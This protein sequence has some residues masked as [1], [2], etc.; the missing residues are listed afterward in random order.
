MHIATIAHR[1][2]S[3]LPLSAGANAYAGVAALGMAALLGFALL[4]MA[5]MTGQDRLAQERVNAERWYF[6]TEAILAEA[7]DVLSA[8]QDAES[9]QR[10]YLLTGRTEY[11]ATYDAGR[12]ELKPRLDRLAAL[13]ADDPG[14]EQRLRRLRQ[15]ADAKLAELDA[16]I[17]ARQTGG[18]SQALAIVQTGQGKDL[19]DKARSIVARMKEEERRRLDRRRDRL[20]QAITDDRTDSLR[21]YGLGAVLLAIAGLGLA[22][23]LGLRG[24]ARLAEEGRRF[25]AL[26]DNIPQLAWMGR[27]DGWLF[28]YNK[29][30]FDYTGTTLEQMQGWGWRRVHHPDHVERVETGFRRTLEA[31][32]PWEDTFPLRGGDGRYRWFLSR[33]QPVRDEAGNV[34]LWFGTNTDITEQRQQEEALERARDEAE[35]AKDAADRA[36]REKSRFL[37]AASHDLR[38]PVQALLLFASVLDGSLAGDPATGA[39]LAKMRLAL[40]ALKKLLEALLDVSRLDAGVIAAEIRPVVLGEMLRRLAVEYEGRVREKALAIRVVPSRLSVTTDPMLLER[41]LRNLIEN[42][43]R[44]TASGRILIGCRRRGSEALLQVCDTGIGIAAEHREAIFHEFFQVGNSE[45]DHTKGLGLGLSIVRRLLQLLGH[46]L[47]MTSRPGRGTCFSLHLPIAPS[48]L[49]ATGEPLI[50]ERPAELGQTGATRALIIDDEAMI[51]TGLTM[52]LEGWGWQVAAVA[53][54]AEATEKVAAWARGPDIILAD[55]R[56]ADGQV[57][58]DA[59][60]A[61]RAA[62][63]RDVPAVIITGD[64]SAD[65]LAAIQASGFAVAHKPVT[66]DRLRAMTAQAMAEEG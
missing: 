21:L 52:L 54:A 2:R 28:W 50:E 20:A 32:E 31:G 10:G 23:L 58:T 61:V 13:M 6:H 36:N 24:R 55:Y 46:H 37:A 62:C 47:T 4:A 49:P 8:L 22:A 41:V 30:W 9:G 18:Q 29:R 51:R 27:P 56:L 45:R 16:T 57:G 63:A 33:A 7:Q 12:R 60:K 15:V 19:M 42:A 48:P 11:L 38:Q 43:I 39:V 14:Q 64:T 65:R 59:V 53:D 17:R 34:V 35:R 5:V 1:L 25:R 66:A 44:Y 26:A 3:L 40:D